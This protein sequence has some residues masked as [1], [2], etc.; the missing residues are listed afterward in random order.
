[1]MSLLVRL[2]IVTISFLLSAVVCAAVFFALKRQETW[3]GLLLT[4]PKTYLYGVGAYLLEG[5]KMA[6]VGGYLL[7]MPVLAVILV[8]FLLRIRTVLYYVPAGGLAL[9]MVP[10]LAGFLQTAAFAQPDEASTFLYLVS[11]AAGGFAY[12][13]IGGANAVPKR[14]T[15]F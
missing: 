6:F 7:Y 13:L 8:G 15:S 14:G 12:W 9:L 10:V 1:M 5:I 4:D 2:V 3:D 11:G